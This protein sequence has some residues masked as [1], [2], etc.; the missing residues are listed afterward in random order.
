MVAHEVTD[1]QRERLWP[2][3]V[4]TYADFAVYQSRT[5]RKIPVVILTPAE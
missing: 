4:D 2:M 1:E 5:K 3:V